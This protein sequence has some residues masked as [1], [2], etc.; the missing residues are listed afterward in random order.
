MK[1]LE[2]DVLALI[3]P[4]D[5]PS[6]SVS[7]ISSKPIPKE[8]IQ[9]RKPPTQALRLANAIRR[10][11]FVM[12]QVEMLGEQ[13]TGGPSPIRVLRFHRYEVTDF[14]LRQAMKLVSPEEKSAMESY[15]WNAPTLKY[16]QEIKRWLELDPPF[17]EEAEQAFKKIFKQLRKVGALQVRM[18][19]T[20]R[21]G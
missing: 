2:L 16:D 11:C 14:E 17:T 21:R 19:R 15:L 4:S 3:C 8:A 10:N 18:R 13:M 9:R 5:T 20:L 1:R 12:P 7:L 6:F